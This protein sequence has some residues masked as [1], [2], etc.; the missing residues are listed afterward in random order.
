M[1]IFLNKEHKRL[2]R[3]INDLDLFKKLYMSFATIISYDY[4]R[5][6]LSY[7]HFRF[8]ETEHIKNPIGHIALEDM[9]GL[10][11]ELLDVED[12]KRYSGNMHKHILNRRIIVHYRSSKDGLTKIYGISAFN[13]ISQDYLEAKMI[14]I[15]DVKSL[16]VFSA[17]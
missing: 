15:E 10:C 3:I 5:D 7:V 11:E 12:C 14:P 6:S 8:D 2:E 1:K 16:S 9:E 13:E 4:N 17:N